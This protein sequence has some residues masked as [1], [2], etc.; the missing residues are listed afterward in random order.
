[1]L[2]VEE[3]L[4]SVA[5]AVGSRRC[6]TERVDLDDALGR[7]LAAD[8]RMDHDVPP[9][10][11]AAMDGF[12]VA[13]TP[14]AGATLEVIGTVPAGT[15]PE[16][17]P[18][19]GQAVR[20]MT[21]APVPA[22]ATRVI[23]FEWTRADEPESAGDAAARDRVVVERVPSDAMHVVA[24]GA[25]VRSGDVVLPEGRRLEAGALGALATAGQLQVEVVL[26]PQVAVLGTGTELAHVASFPKP[27][28]VRNSNTAL[29]RA[30][31]RRAGASAIDLGLAVDVED[32]L[33]WAIRKGFGEDVLVLSGGVSRGD[34]DLVPAALEAEGVRQ[35][36][37]RWKVQP[38]GPLWFG[39]HE[40]TRTLV[41]GL[42]GNPAASF[43]GFEILV[44]PALRGLLGLPVE[45]RRTVKA[46]YRGPLAPGGD[47][48]RYRPVRLESAA[49]GAL[50]A[51]A[52][53]WTGSGDPFV[54]A[55]A[56][57]LAAL[58]DAE[59]TPAF[60]AD[61]EPIVDVLPLDA[62]A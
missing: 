39:V 34:L 51:K 27:G 38:G 59:G 10:A 6:R 30:Q 4:A 45:A 18:R 32:E 61:G 58:P 23:P 36:F 11:Q 8:V 44:V 43:V 48:R 55:R 56:E 57:A 13:E 33:R 16:V 41:F 20:I 54:S 7:T 15:W 2:T 19:P 14:V 35:V 5:L 50:V 53:P 40:S 12:A 29:L 60:S 22:G 1:M 37:H 28:Q 3:A 46:R 49:D 52:L 21:G 62:W 42:P 47:R 25:H 9:F 31:A 26:R 24:Q 17:A